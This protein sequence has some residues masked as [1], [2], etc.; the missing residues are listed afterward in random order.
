MDPF[1]NRMDLDGLHTLV[2][3]RY[4]CLCHLTLG[5][6]LENPLQAPARKSNLGLSSRKC[7]CQQTSVWWVR[8]SLPPSALSFP[9]RTLVHGLPKPAPQIYLDVPSV[10]KP[11]LKL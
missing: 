3:S 4:I 10:S 9:S 5:G 7:V 11:K 2:I 8:R 6:K 1:Q